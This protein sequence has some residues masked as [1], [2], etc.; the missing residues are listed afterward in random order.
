[1]RVLFLSFYYSPDLSAGAFRNTALVNSLLGQLP[2]GSHIDVVTTLP[3]RYSSFSVEAP[4]HEVGD[5]VTVERIKLPEHKSGMVD[6]SRAFLTFAKEALR[7]S[8]RADY[9]LVYASSSRLM[10]GALGEFIASR[11]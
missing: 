9:D 2:P 6:Q 5:R 1:M 10:T 8:Q 3:S 4:A 11:R 7:L